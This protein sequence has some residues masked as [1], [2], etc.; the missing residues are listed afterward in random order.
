[1]LWG[2]L[3][4]VQREQNERPEGGKGRGSQGGEKAAKEE[5][6]QCLQLWIVPQ[7]GL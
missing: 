1:M 5:E 7:C 3:C 6:A 4:A 2:L